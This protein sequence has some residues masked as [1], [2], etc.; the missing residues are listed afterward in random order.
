MIYIDTKLN[1]H[2]KGMPGIN[3]S[4]L[5]LITDQTFMVRQRIGGY[6]GEEVSHLCEMSSVKEFAKRLAQLKSDLVTQGDRV[7]DMLQPPGKCLTTIP[8]SE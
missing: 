2:R 8:L 7:T 4:Q 3:S 6:T 5:N 1:H